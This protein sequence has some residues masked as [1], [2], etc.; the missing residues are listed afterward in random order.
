MVHRSRRSFMAF[1][2]QSKLTRASGFTLIE[3]LIIAPVVIIVISGFIALMINMV[4]DVLVTRD[5]NALTYETQDALN[6]IEQDTRLTTQFLATSGTFTAPQ[7]S[8]SNFTG[9]NAFSSTNTLIMS[10]LTTDKNP[11][12][13]TRQLVFYAGQPNLCGPQQSYNR[14]FLTKIMYFVKDGSLWRRTVLPNNNTNPVLDDDT[15]CSTPWQRDS[16][17]PGY[18]VSTRCQTNDTELVK[19]VET[20]GVKYFADSQSVTDLGPSQALSATTIEVTINGKKTTVGKPFTTTGS[21]RATRLNNIDVDIPIPGVPVVNA[22]VTTSPSPSITFSWAKIPLASS[23]IISYVKNAETPVNTTTNSQTPTF[24]VSANRTDTVTIQVSAR[25]SSGT[26]AAGTAAATIPAWNECGLQ[27][28]WANY[29]E[30]DYGKSSFTKTKEDVVVLR[31]L[32]KTGTGGSTICT[33][34]VGYRPTHRLVFQT[35]TASASE[36]ASR[37]DVFPTG[38]VYADTASSGW[39]TLS[40]ID[41]LSSTAAY[42]WTA[43]TFNAGQPGQPFGGTE[44]SPLR[45]AIDTTGRVHVQ[46]M[47]KSPTYSD[48]TSVATLNPAG[49]QPALHT[50]LPA[51]SGAGFNYTAI[52]PDRTINARGINTSAWYSIQA[53]FYPSSFTTGWIS[54]F[55]PPMTPVSTWSEF[56]PTFSKPEYRKSSDGIVKVKGMI[57][58]GSNGTTVAIL[59]PGYR[60][61]KT[62]VIASVAWG[63][64]ARIDVATDGRIIV[65]N[66]NSGWTSLDSVTFMAEQ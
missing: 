22:S 61:A 4:G 2:L 25:N 19:N 41:F 45:S 59:P 39:L 5:Q 10:G 26:S 63:A 11:S 48:P 8:D 1:T 53:L 51:N 20:F 30:T 15:L 28:V 50:F 29:N 31:G 21:I 49:T 27:G 65:T 58:G 52:G 47:I 3:M 14:V 46:G 35:M 38:E 13:A 7:G 16:C 18:S 17:S 66:G 60:P 37:I 32:V 55:S 56:S 42:T 9:T 12:D 57:K 6:R 34:P 44:F 40:G 33:L 24:T 62:L 43:G 64:P 36:T 23:Y 54:L